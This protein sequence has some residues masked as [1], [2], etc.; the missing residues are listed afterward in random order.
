MK[1]QLLPKGL[2]S[3]VLIAS[4]NLSFDPELDLKPFSSQNLAN[5][6][7]SFSK[8]RLPKRAKLY[9][10][11]TQKLI[12]YKIILPELINAS[13][14]NITFYTLGQ[15]IKTTIFIFEKAVLFSESEVESPGLEF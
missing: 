2:R 3:P 13:L 14:N 8:L 4:A 15:K 11:M 5:A 12:K 10:K 6:K 7:S 9:P 1:Q